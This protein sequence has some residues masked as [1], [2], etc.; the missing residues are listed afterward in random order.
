[1]SLAKTVT[2]MWPTENKI[3]IHLVI[4]DNDRPDLGEDEQE[5]IKETF[6]RNV[7]KGDMANKVRDELELEA[8]AE[9]NRYKA[10][11]ARYDNPIY[12][13][14]VTQIDNNLKL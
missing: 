13:T 4:T 5:V 10:L 6:S 12:Q 9:I 8:Q 1:M 14:K 11:R 7:P 3:G 2:K